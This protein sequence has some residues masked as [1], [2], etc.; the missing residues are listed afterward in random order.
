MAWRPR[1]D[2]FSEA[3]GDHV[4]EGTDLRDPG[5]VRKLVYAGGGSGGG[6]KKDAILALHEEHPDATPSEIA[7]QVGASPRYVQRVLKKS[8]GPTEG[9]E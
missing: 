4:T 1:E 9:E 6:S 3:D 2:I 5:S 8:K 7:E